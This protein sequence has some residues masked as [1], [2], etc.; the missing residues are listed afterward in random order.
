MTFA[1]LGISQ[2]VSMTINQARDDGVLRQIDRRNTRGSRASNCEDSIF[3]DRDVGVGGHTA[4]S[5]VDQT[6][7][8]NDRGRLRRI[9]LGERRRA[10]KDKHE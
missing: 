5:D 8:M 10:C 7:G 4:G 2:Y 6:A 1:D 9:L 3:G